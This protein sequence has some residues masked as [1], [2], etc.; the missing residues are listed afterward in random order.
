MVSSQ[1]FPKVTQLVAFFAL[2]D[3][4]NHEMDF[5]SIYNLLYLSG[6][7]S[8]YALYYHARATIGSDLP[9]KGQQ[10]ANNERTHTDSLLNLMKMLIKN[11]EPYY[12][13]EK[14]KIVA[15][16]SCR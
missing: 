6:K 5:L 3:W 9:P 11:T 16:E 14:R 13:P 2:M 7:R 8:D 1:H 4:H 10:L 15:D 12:H